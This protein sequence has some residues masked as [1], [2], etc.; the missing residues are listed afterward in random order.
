MNKNIFSEIAKEYSFLDDYENE[1]KE[2]LANS[3]KNQKRQDN[4]SN[5]NKN[6]RFFNNYPQNE[7]TSGDDMNNEEMESRKYLNTRYGSFV[8]KSLDPSKMDDL[9]YVYKNLEVDRNV[10]SNTQ[11]LENSDKQMLEDVTE[12]IKKKEIKL[13][14]FLNKEFNILNRKMIN[15]SILCYSDPNLFT[16]HEAKLCAESCHKNI[17]EAAKFAE[18]LNE[19]KKEKLVNCLDRAKDHEMNKSEDKIASFFKCYEDLLM[20]FEAMEKEIKLEFANYI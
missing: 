20:D 6:Q 8:N 18:H 2:R 14:A 12:T 10:E 7:K 4:T 3:Q 13:Y 5:M 11:L 1:R 9:E 19:E 16:V 15:C 17:K